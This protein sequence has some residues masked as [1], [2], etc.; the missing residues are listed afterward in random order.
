MLKF[1]FSVSRVIIVS[2]KLTVVFKNQ[3]SGNSRTN[4]GTT[5][6]YK[7]TTTIV[8][9]DFII[10]RDKLEKVN[11]DLTERTGKGEK[12]LLSGPGKTKD[13]REC[14]EHNLAIQQDALS[15]REKRLMAHM[16]LKGKSRQNI[17]SLSHCLVGNLGTD[18]G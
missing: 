7:K 10:S 15:T 11:K 14:M 13:S 5:I 16:G 18:A 6:F 9:Q 4:L 3:T 17:I 8:E 12:V 1:Y 2:D